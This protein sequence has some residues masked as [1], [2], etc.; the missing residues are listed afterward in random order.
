MKQPEMKLN[1]TATVVILH[2]FCIGSF[3]GLLYEPAVDP[4]ATT[5]PPWNTI[6][7]FPVVQ[8]E[9]KGCKLD[10]SGALFGSVKAACP[11]DHLDR[12]R[13]CP[14]L[15]AWI[16]AAYA[17]T[18]LHVSAAAAAP[19]PP[20][21]ELPMMPDED[22]TCVGSLQD[23]LHSNKMNI[24][25]PNATCDTVLCFCGIRLHHIASLTCPAAFN[26]SGSGTATPTSVVT[27][28]EKNCRQSSFSGCTQ[29]LGALRKIKGGARN[30]TSKGRNGESNR[31]RKMLNEDCQLMGLT[32]LL[33]RNK[34]AYIPTVS[35][36]LRAIMYSGSQDDRWEIENSK[37]SQENMPLAVDSLQFKNG[38]ASSSPLIWPLIVI[39]HIVHILSMHYYHFYYS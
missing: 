31:M 14:V 11:K 18:A 1:F 25:Q 8:T 35:A 17:R 3:A 34:T 19:P 20:A 26:V 23:W 12:N 27:D 24:P 21:L 13:C 16:Y 33:A 30:A 9:T 15:A 36:V 22:Q 4:P 6:P 5:N 29:C 10:F 32:W 7:A 39:S 38:D 28:L 37:C 2:C